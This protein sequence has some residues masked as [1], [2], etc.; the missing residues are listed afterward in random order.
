MLFQLLL[1]LSAG[2]Y[3]PRSLSVPGD[4]SPTHTLLPLTCS[5]NKT[6]LPA[7]PWKE[8]VHNLHSQLGG[9]HVTE[10][11]LDCLVLKPNSTAFTSPIGL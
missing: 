3:P 10:R 2:G 9:C 7:S 1:H 6:K 11:L 8:L 4:T 5:D